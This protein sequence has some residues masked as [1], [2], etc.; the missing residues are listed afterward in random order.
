MHIPALLTLIERLV[1]EPSV[2]SVSP[3]WDQ[4]NIRVIDL[5]AEWFSALGFKTEKLPVPGWLNG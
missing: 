2:S 5:L 4:S 1:A 3:D